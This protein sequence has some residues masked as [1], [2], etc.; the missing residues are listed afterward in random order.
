[1]IP[2][3]TSMASPN[4]CIRYHLLPLPMLIPS[5]PLIDSTIWHLVYIQILIKLRITLRSMD[6][7]ISF[8]SDVSPDHFS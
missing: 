4:R 3:T 6:N 2:F 8:L 5:I 1:M 7:P